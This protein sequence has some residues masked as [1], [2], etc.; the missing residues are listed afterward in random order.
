MR[1]LLLIGLMCWAGMLSAQ[2][3]S[4]AYRVEDVKPIV[5]KN[6]LYAEAF[7]YSLMSLSVNYERRFI[8]SD[9]SNLGL[10]GGMTYFFGLHGI[11]EL[12][13][14]F[15]GQKHFLE[16]GVGTSTFSGWHFSDEPGQSYFAFKDMALS[17]RIGYRY[18]GE[19]GFLVKA[20]PYVFYDGDNLRVWPSAS[21]GFSF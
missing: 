21:V 8:L 6:S 9:W 13:A 14:F 3:A 12:N 11:A 7:G 1:K 15:F 4:K 2:T 10:R 20:A 18:A 5:R 19:K 17:G 16:L